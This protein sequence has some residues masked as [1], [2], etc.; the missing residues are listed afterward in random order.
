MA[1]LSLRSFKSQ[2]ERIQTVK[3]IFGKIA[4]KHLLHRFL[5]FLSLSLKYSRKQYYDIM[6]DDDDF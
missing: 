6:C 4:L 1:L 2:Q 3:T 5:W